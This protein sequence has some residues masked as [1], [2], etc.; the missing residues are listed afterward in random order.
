MLSRVETELLGMPGIPKGRLNIEVRE[1]QVVLRGEVNSE[2]QGRE[3]VSAAGSVPGVYGVQSL[4]H[5]R[6]KPAPNKAASR[7]AGA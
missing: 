4:L 1:G 7:R 3:L 5:V 2:E 6:S